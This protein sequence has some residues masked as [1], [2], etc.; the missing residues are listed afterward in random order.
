MPEDKQNTITRQIIYQ[1][2]K[3]KPTFTS[4]LLSLS[5]F[6]FMSLLQ[7]RDFSTKLSRDFFFAA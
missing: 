6:C 2:L 5:D 1:I 4:N 3:M 7:D